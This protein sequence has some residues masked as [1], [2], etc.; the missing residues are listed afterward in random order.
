M[1]E[2][3]TACGVCGELKFSWELEYLPFHDVWVCKKHTK[4]ELQRWKL[5]KLKEEK[6]VV[7][8]K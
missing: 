8:L 5:K 2:E 4:R 3:K 6:K 1:S 7:A